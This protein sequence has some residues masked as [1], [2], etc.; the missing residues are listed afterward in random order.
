MFMISVCK[1]MSI[2]IAYISYAI[3]SIIEEGKKES[4]MKKLWVR[5]IRKKIVTFTFKLAFTIT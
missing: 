3:E 4:E 1:E 2:L 5:K